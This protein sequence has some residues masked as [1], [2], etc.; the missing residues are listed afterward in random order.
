MGVGGGTYLCVVLRSSTRRGFLLVW[1]FVVGIV[2]GSVGV[3]NYVFTLF[4][5]MWL[6]VVAMVNVCISSAWP[7]LALP[8][9]KQSVSWVGAV[10]VVDIDDR[11]TISQ[12]IPKPLP[13]SLDLILCTS[14]VSTDSRDDWQQ[15]LPT[16]L[17]S[18][19]ISSSALQDV[20]TVRDS[21]EYLV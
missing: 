16:S 6:C 3:F 21:I 15:H 5:L 9:C 8:L 18:R 11:I 17:L 12:G 20:L 19:F 2:S 10:P 1:V 7:G 4:V 14:L 13:S